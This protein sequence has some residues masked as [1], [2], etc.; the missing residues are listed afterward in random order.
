LGHTTSGK[1][2]QDYTDFKGS[3]DGGLAPKQIADAIYFAYNQP[4]HVCIREIVICPTKQD[5]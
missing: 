2:K 3:I 5:A 1:I 4:Q